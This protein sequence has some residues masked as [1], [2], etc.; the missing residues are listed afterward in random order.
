MR[1]RDLAAIDVG[2][3]PSVLLMH[4]LGGFKEI[5]EAQVDSLSRA[6]FRVLAP[7]M[8]GHGG[9]T[10]IEARSIADM[11]ACIAE[12][13][14]SREAGTTCVVG[15]SMGGR[16]MFQLAL[17]QPRLVQALV[18]VGAQSEAPSGEYRTAIMEIRAATEC[19]G[20]AGFQ[21]AFE[22][23]H[24][25]PKRAYQDPV[26]A[27]WYWPLFRRNEAAGLLRGLDAILTM[28]NLTPRLNT[29]RAPTLAVVGEQDEPFLRHARLY[30]RLIP[31]SRHVRIQHCRH[32]PMVDA[33]TQFNA[34]LL[35]FLRDVP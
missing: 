7:D 11:A 33:T 8:P 16:V 5:W 15:H 31:A 32:Y 4:G 30:N 26:Y 24:E 9:S 14:R 35:A 19:S 17:G 28:N 34:E 2:H 13:L 23:A 25:I 21:K 20:L 29:V 12:F 10:A 27:A 22:E 1:E 6:G 3:G 18:A